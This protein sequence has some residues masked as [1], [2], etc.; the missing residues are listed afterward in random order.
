MNSRIKKQL[1]SSPT[2]R[3][4]KSVCVLVVYWDSK[5]NEND[6]YKQ[7]DR[8][9]KVFPEG[10]GYEVE[11]FPIPARMSRMALEHK[12]SSILLRLDSS[13]LFILH[14]GGHADPDDKR[15]RSVWAA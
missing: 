5:G 2:R 10:F 6:G 3:G 8:I 4:Y 11:T 1:T 14:Y 13:S 7:A 9:A 15:C 12:V